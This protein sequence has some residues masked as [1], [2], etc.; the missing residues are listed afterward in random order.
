MFIRILYHILHKNVVVL[1]LY[2]HLYIT[3]YTTY[4]ILVS[5]D[6]LRKGQVKSMIM[7]REFTVFENE[8]DWRKRK[9]L[10][11][12]ESDDF[13]RARFTRSDE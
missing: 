7:N 10:Q 3:I 12:L 5:S 13:R 9:R 1:H 6:K 4:C 2:M 8:M 11:L